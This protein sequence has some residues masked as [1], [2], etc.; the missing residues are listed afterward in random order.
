MQPDDVVEVRRGTGK[1]SREV[2][3]PA[4]GRIA[5]LECVSHAAGSVT[6]LRDAVCLP[7]A[8]TASLHSLLRKQR[9]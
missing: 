6:K 7:F 5:T 8:D 4:V 2:K 1:R 9:S 3:S